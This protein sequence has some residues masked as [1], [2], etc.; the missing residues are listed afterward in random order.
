MLHSFDVEQQRNFLI[1]DLQTSM[2]CTRHYCTHCN[3]YM[4]IVQQLLMYTST[5]NC[6]LQCRT[7]WKWFTFANRLFWKHTQR[8][9]IPHWTNRE[10]VREELDV[11]SL[12]QTPPSRSVNWCVDKFLEWMKNRSKA[13]TIIILKKQIFAYMIFRSRKT[14]SI[15]QWWFSKQF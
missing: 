14:N 2:Y 1:Q 13:S 5:K 11:R 7:I 6:Q 4:F 12:I 9:L 3:S 8:H 15:L 10:F